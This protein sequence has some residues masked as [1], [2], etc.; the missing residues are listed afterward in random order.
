M[1]RTTCVRDLKRRCLDIIESARITFLFF[2]FSLN[3][4]EEN[5]HFY[6]EKHF[7]ARGRDSYVTE[8]E[9]IYLCG[10]CM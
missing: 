9:M 8:E 4:I 7:A 2:F 3:S 5:C 6:G 1:S 10:I